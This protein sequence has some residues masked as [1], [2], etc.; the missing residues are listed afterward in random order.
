[1]SIEKFLNVLKEAEISLALDGESLVVKGAKGRLNE[2]IRTY[3]VENKEKLVEI[4]KSGRNLDGPG[5]Q[6]PPNR[7]GEAGAAIA[8][9]LLTLIELTQGDIDRIVAQV[10]GGAANIQDIYQLTPLQDG[11]LFHH[12]LADVGDPYLLTSHISFQDRNSLELFL[13]AV[14]KVVD[15]HDTLRTAFYWE[16]LSTPAQVVLRRAELQVAHVEFDAAAGPLEQQ[17]AERFDSSR[18]RIDLGRAPLLS[19]I[20]GRVRGSERC[21]VMQRFHH[22]IGDHSTLALLREEVYAILAGAEAALA[23]SEPFRNLVARV[24]SGLGQEEHERFFREMLGDVSEPSLAFGHDDVYQKGD[25]IDDAKFALPDA[26]NDRLRAQARRYGVSLA[27]LCHLAWGQVLAR[28]AGEARVVFGTVLLGRIQTNEGSGPAAGLFINTLPLRLDLGEQ[29]VETAVRKTHARLADILRHEHAPLALAQRCSGVAATAPLFNTLLNY[30]HGADEAPIEQASGNAHPLSEAVFLGNEERTNYPITLSVEDFGRSMGLT[31]QVAHPLSAARICGY[32]QRALESLADALERRPEAPVRTLD[33]LP[34]RERELLLEAWNRTEAEYSR[35]RCVHKVFEDQCRR[36]P[37]AVALEHGDL[38]VGYAELNARANRLAHDLIGS[39][40]RPGDHVATVMERGLQLVVAQLAILKAGAV[41][42]PIDRQ[43]PRARQEWILADCGAKRVLAEAP[44]AFGFDVQVIGDASADGGEA[45]VRDPELDISSEAPAYVMYTSGSTGTPKGVVVPHRAIGR[46]VVNNGYAPFDAGDAI[47]FASNPSFD[48]STMEVWGALLNGGRIVV[49]DADVFIDAARFERALARHRV[50]ALFV[51]TALFNQ[52]ARTI[53]PALAGLKYLMCGGERNDPSAFR[54]V[55]DQG[56]LQSIIHCYGPTETTTFALT[57]PI[58]RAHDG[59]ANLPIGRPIGNVRAYLLDE[60]RNPVP[61]GAVGELYIGGTGVALGYLNRPELTAER[62][63]R[64]PFAGD[65]HMY[66][67]GDLA[68]YLADG[69]LEFIGRNDHQVK[70]RGFRIELGEIETRLAELPE[71]LEAAVLAREEGGEKR[72]VAYALPADADGDS[73]SFAAALRAHLSAKLPDYMVPSAFVRMQAWPLNANGKLDRKALPAPEAAAFARGTFQPPQG[74]LEQ[75]L[76]ALWQELLGVGEVGRHDNFFELG[77]HSLLALQLVE[78]LRQLNLRVEVRR[79]FI[80]PVLCE[81][82]QSLQREGWVTVPPNA[83]A[84]DSVAITPDMLP[85][86]DLDQDEIDRIVARVPGGIANIQDIYALAPLQDGILFHHRFSDEGDP[87]VLTSLRSFPNRQLLD[88]FLGVLQRLVERHDILRTAFMWEDLSVPVQVVLREAKLPVQEFEPDPAQGP[89]AEQLAAHFDARRERMDLSRAPLLHYAFAHDRDNGRW[90]LMQ[91]FHHLI[92][93]H[94]TLDVLRDEIAALMAGKGDALAP[95][96]PFRNLVAQARLGIAQSEHEAFFRE[97]LGDVDEPTLPF[98]LADVHQAGGGVAESSLLLPDDLSRSLRQHARRLGVGVASLCHLA[99]GQVLSRIVDRDSVVFGTVLFGRIQSS[100][101][102]DRAAGLF[103]NT[104]PL[105]LDL[106]ETDVE[107]AARAAHARLADL[108]AHEH[109]SLALA[110]RCSGVAAPSPLFSSLL[111]Y[112]HNRLLDVSSEGAEDYL[113][114][115][116]VEFLGTQ[117]RTN[118]PITMSVE[119]FG[120]RLGLTALVVDALSAER[121]CGY[122]RQALESLSLALATAPRTPVRDLEVLGPQEAAAAQPAPAAAIGAS[123]PDACIHQLFEQRAH[124]DPDAIALV[125]DD[126]RLSYGELNAQ[127]N[128]LAHHLIGLGVAADERVAICAERGP[129]LVIGLLAI[130]KAGGAYVPL[131]PVYS[132]ERLETIA[133]DSAPRFV[134]ADDVGRAAL[135]ERALGERSVVDL[136]PLRAG[137]AAAWAAQCD[138]DPA[139]AGLS[140]ANLAYVIYTSGS[141][142]VPK[143]VMVE[144]TQVVRLFDATRAGF[145]FDE[146]DVW[147]L[148]HSCAFD[149]SVWELWGALRYGGRL[150]LVSHEVARSAADFYRLVCRE[151]V[152]VLN[153]TP[154]AFKAFIEAQERSDSAHALRYV[155]FGGEALEPSMLKPWYARHADGGPTLVNMYG[156]TETTVHVTYRALS[157]DD[158]ARSASPVGKPLADLRI[159]LLD[160][161]GKPVPLQATGEIYVGGAGVARGYLNREEL[162]AQR[163]LADPFDGAAGAR[164]YRSG[165]LARYGRDGELEF[166]GRNDHQVKIRGFR[167]ELG[168]IEARLTEHPWVREATV[169]AFGDGAEK[170]LA[171]YFI[172]AGDAAGDDAQEGLAAGLRAH[173]AARLPD[174]MLPSAFVEVEAWPLTPNGKLDRKALPAV[175]AQSRARRAYEAPQGE[176]ERL[177]ARLWEELLGLERVGRNDQFFELGG[178]S[179]LAVQL[180]ERLRRMH[181][182]VEVRRLFAAP[183]LRE[184]AAALEQGSGVA[185]PPNQ[186]VRGTTAITPDMLPLIDLQQEDI[187]RI[188]A[189]VPGG[190]AN[191]QDIYGL[192]PLQDGIVFHHRLTLDADPYLMRSVVTFPDRALLDRFIQAVQ[193]LVDRHDILR[194]AFFWEGL[195]APAQ[196]VL[197]QAA[198][199]VTELVLDAH[200]GP[201][202]EQLSRRYDARHHK[203]D[204]TQAPL[205]RFVI[206]R[207]PGSERWVVLQLRHHLV[208]DAVSV[209]I[210]REEIN[211]IL[212]GAAASLAEPPPFRN[213]VAQARLGLSPEQHERFFDEM[214]GDVDEPTLPYGLTDVHRD[215]GRMGQWQGTMPLALSDRLRAQAQRLGI[216]LA[217]LCH[218]AWGQVLARI[219]GN[220][221]VV[222]GTVLFGRMQAG[223]GADRAAGL[224]INTLPLRLDLGEIGAER[225]ARQ[226]H[227]RLAALMAHEHASLALAQ[228]CS[229]VG[230]PAPLFSSVVN[231]RNLVAAPGSDPAP[232]EQPLIDTQWVMGDRYTNYPMMLTLEDFGRSLGCIVHVMQPH[233]P[234]RVWDYMACALDSLATALEASPAA[235]MRSLEVLPQAERGLLLEQWNATQAPYPRDRSVHR[236]FEAQAQATPDA[237]AVVH[238]RR[239]LTFAEL[240]AEANALA[241]HLI[242]LGVRRG[243]RVAICVERGPALAIGLLAILK[244]GGAYV[245]LD[246]VYPSERLMRVLDDAAPTALL[247]D[248]SGRAALDGAAAAGCAIVDL[249]SPEDATLATAW[250]GQPTADPRPAGANSGDLAYVI[251]TSGSTGIPK[252]VQIEHRQL[253]NFLCSMASSFALAPADRWLA[254]TSISFDIAALELYLPLIS[255]SPVVLA[256]HADAIDSSRLRELIREHA[257]R[258]MQAT[259]ATWNALLAAGWEGDS[260]LTALCGGEAMPAH[261]PARLGARCKSLWNLYGPTETTIWSSILQVAPATGDAPV[262]IGRPIANT[263]MYLLDEA[264]QPVPLGA[265]GELYIGG[266]GVARGYHNR[267]ELNAERFLHDPFAGGEARM[268]RTGDQARYLTDGNIEFLGRNDHQVKIRG[269]R[270]EL[271]EIE[272]RLAGHASVREAVVTVREDHGDKRLVA[273]VAGA[274]EHDEWIAELRAHLSAGLPDY[275]VPAAIVRLD[276]LPLTPNGKV[277][278]KALPA[279]DESSYAQREFEAPE[280][281]IER[282]L[283]GLWQSLLQVDKV[284]RHHDFF[285]LGGHSLLVVRLLARVRQS[286]GVEL[287]VAAFFAHST[288]ARLAQAVADAG[289]RAAEGADAPIV[290]VSREQPMPLSFAQQRLWFLAQLDGVS[291]T[292]HMP[293]AL[294]IRG[295]LDRAALRRTLDALMARHEALRSVFATV[296]GQPQLR[297]LPAATPLPL[298]EYDFSERDDAAA[299]LASLGEAETKLPFDLANG[300]LIRARLIRMPHDEHVL[301][302]CQHHIVSDGWS[303]G[304][305]TREL[306]QLYAAFSEGRENP[307]APLPIQYPDYAAWQ[308]QWLGGERLQRQAEFWRETLSEVPALLELPTDRPRPAK[309]DFAAALVPVAFDAELTASLRR[310]SQAHGTTLFMTLMAAW[311]TVLSRLSGQEQVVVGVPTANRGRPETEGLLGLFVNT[312][313]LPVRLDGEPSVGELLARVRAT[314]LAAQDHQDLPFEQVVEIVRPQRSLNHSPL[315]Q[316]LFNWQNNDVRLPELGSLH[317]EQAATRFD[318]VKFDLELSLGEADGQIQGYLKYVTSLFDAETVQRQIGYL[319]ALLKAMVADAGQPVAGIDLLSPAER[320]LQLETWNDTD[321]PFPQDLCIHQLFERQAAATPEAVAV[322]CGDRALGYRDLNEQANKLAHGL[323]GRGVRADARVAICVERSLEMVVGL[324]AIMKAG[325]AYVPLDLSYPRDRLAQMLDDAAPAMVLTDAAGREALGAIVAADAIVLDLHQ[326]Q[327]WASMP[328]G[329]PVAVGLTSRNLAYIIYTSGSTGRPKGV[330]TEHRAVVNRL[331]WIQQGYAPLDRDEVVLQKTSFAFDVSVWELFWPLLNG[332]RLALAPPGAHKDPAALIGLVARHGVTTVHFVPSM[333]SV[334]LA[335]PGV[336]GCVSLRKLFCSGEAL[337]AANVYGWQRK[338]PGAQLYNLYGPTE[339]AIEASAWTCPREFDGRVLIG[340]PIANVRMYV[341]DAAGRPAPLGAIG[342]LHIGGTAVA[343]GYLNRPELTAERFLDDPFDAGPDARMYKSGDL[344]RYLADGRIECLGRNDDQVKVRGFRIELGEIRSRLGGHAKVREAHVLARDYGEEKRLIGYVVPMQADAAGADL[345]AELRTHLATVLPDY[346]V[347]SAIVCLDRLPVTQNGK[348]DHKALPEPEEGAAERAGYQAPVGE[349]ELALAALWQELLQVERV[350]RQDEFFELG[351]HSLLAVRMLAHIRQRLGVELP[352][353]MLFGSS[354]L[355]GLAAALADAGARVGLEGLP[356][357]AALA[358]DRPLPL[359]FAQQRL[360]ILSQWEG[361]S[362]TY[363][364]PLA[365]RIRGELDKVALRRSLDA[366]VARHE[367]LR[368]VFDAVGGLPQV[369]VLGPDLGFRMLEHDLR[370]EPDASAQLARIGEEEARSPFDLAQ[371]P[372]IRGRL[373]QTG[374]QEFVLLLTQHHIVSDGWSVGVLSRELN[375]LYRAFRAGRPNPLAPLEIQYPDYAAWQNQWLSGERLARQTEFWRRALADAPVLLELPTDRPRPEQQEF[376]AGRVAIEL[377]ADATAALKRLSQRHGVTLFMTLMAAWA[378]VLSRLSGQDEVVIGTPT[379]NRGRPETEG[380]IGFFVNTLALPVSVAG[381]PSVRELLERVRSI[382]LA[383]Q[384]HQDLPFEQVVEIVQP[385]RRLD[386]TPIFQAMFSWQ[387]HEQNRLELPGLQVSP[388]G[389]AGVEPVKFDLELNLNEIGDVVRGDLSYAKSLFDAQTI[390]R[391]VGYLHSALRAMAADSE[392]AVDA[393]ELLSSAER[394]LLLRTWNA[395]DADYPRDRCIHQLIEARAHRAPDAIALVHRDFSLSYGALNAQANRLA[396][397][398]IGLGVRPDDTVAICVDRGPALIVGQL[399][400]LKAG[401][402]YVPLDPVYPSE[403]LG[404]VL[405]D[406]MP[407]IVLADAAGRAALDAAALTGRTVVALDPPGPAAQAP[408]AALPDTDPQVPALAPT[409]LAYVIYTSGSTGLPKGV[410]IEHAGL[411]NQVTVLQRSY[412]LEPGDR[413]LQFAGPSFDMSVEEIFGALASGATLVLGDRE[414][415]ADPQR[416]FELCESYGLTVANL[417]TRFWQQLAQDPQ[418]PMAPSLRQIAI[419][420]EAVSAAALAAWWSRPG[421]RPALWNAYGPTEATVNACLLRCEASSNPRSIGA[422][423]A[424]GRIYLL[425]AHAHP[426]PRGSVGEIHIGGVGVARGYLNRPDLTAERFLVDPFRDEPGARMYKSG[427]LA[428]Y[429]P[430]G[431]LEFLGRND[432]QVKIRGFRIELGEIEARL[433]EHPLVREAMVLVREEH[434]D[435]RLVAYVTPS[436][437]ESDAIEWVVALRTHLMARLPDYMVPSAFVRIEEWPLTPNGKLD[438]KAL[439]KPDADAYAQGAYEAP[440]GGV[441]PVLARIWQALLRTDRIGRHDNFFELGGHSLLAVQMLEQ[442]RQHG[443]GTDIR[444]IFAAPTIAKLAAALDTY[445]DIDV[446]ANAIA[447]DARTISP[448]MLPLIEL[449]QRDIDRIVAQVPGGVANVQDIYALSPLQEGLLFHHL[450]ASAGDPYL[451]VSVLSFADRGL[452]DRFVGAVQAVVDRHDILRTAFFWEGLST[453]AQVVLRKVRMQ[454]T[455]LELD[456]DEGPIADQLV[457][458]FDTYH[459]RIDISQAPLLRFFASWDEQNGRWLLLYL[460]HH[461]VD[462]HAS[463]STLREE[464]YA[465]LSGRGDRLGAS[466]PFRN[467]VAR[468]RLGVP[469]DEHERYFRK[470]LAGVTEPT[471]PFGLAEVHEDDRR[472]GRAARMLPAPLRDRL[473]AQARRLGVGLASLCHLAWGHVLARSVSHPTVVFGTVLFGRMQAEERM[474]QSVGLFINTLPFRVD[475]GRGDAAAD[476]RRVHDQLAELLLHEHASLAAAQRCSDVPANSPLFSALLNYRHSDAPAAADEQAAG[477]S[478]ELDILHIRD[479]VRNNYPITMC[480]DDFGLDIGLTGLVV[481]S[482]GAER[483]CGY[484]ERAL[485]SLADE[486][487]SAAHGALYRLEILAPRERSQLLTEW[488]ATEAWYPQDRSVHGLFEEQAQ[489]TPQAPAVVHGARTLSYA[490]VNEQANRLAHRLIELG[491]GAQTRVAIC[492]DRSPAMVIAM[493]AV[494]KSGAAYVPLD[495]AYPSERLA[496][497]LADAAPGLVLSDAAGRAALGEAA[498]DGRTALDLE[499]LCGEGDAATAWSDRPASDPQVAGATSSDLAYVIYTSG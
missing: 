232:A 357:I 213:L 423:I 124:E 147:C 168:E 385:P 25:G 346:M 211:A 241:H 186:I 481:E 474:G 398:L 188:L 284:G 406:A 227:D 333:L 22:L 368:T 412:G 35:E 176:I 115:G 424:N 92:G 85:L 427:D 434:A 12:R 479:E 277:D 309:Q 266:D 255:G 206:A 446:P 456:G 81:L 468:A 95:P 7:I 394:E 440:Q 69:N 98:G 361:V 365:M 268:Y 26:L 493:L 470:M 435:R 486:L 263:R 103:I 282:V 466:Q 231:Y 185:V 420:G 78:R 77:G 337:P 90:L 30:R 192:A 238:R 54:S 315:F 2:E 71:V 154:S 405:V 469:R 250:A 313:A 93:D 379:A 275:M 257:I 296:D 245:P 252:G 58:T 448:E 458:R 146:R 378:A 204:L 390:E 53:A 73:Q 295:D 307:L 300:P 356:P 175:D 100:D 196:V 339:T 41:Y 127:A 464:V 328:A 445:R 409:N 261:F 367:T 314:V 174:Y 224:F 135:G 488:N 172:A 454:V 437:P 8:P 40:I 203:V 373:V 236:L 119:D 430:N 220:E 401:G 216:G 202:G 94:S 355:A 487:E 422:P 134:L 354:T 421:H 272:A 329:D 91:R 165:D 281:E 321:A 279:P 87:Y 292:Y 447:A 285:E 156:I 327:E 181:L 391:Q 9:E 178:H 221:R 291:A 383:A 153:Q 65:G 287:P 497:V 11:I 460:T 286:L 5:M 190:I 208:E 433:S 411:C 258:I 436:E 161:H 349:I 159:H 289:G 388:E 20:V 47:A 494:L 130:L 142:G 459:Y 302:L 173:L 76:A 158:C 101:G 4:L 305:L 43:L 182:H 413:V 222:F 152:T 13:Q 121:I 342:E 407:S 23:P 480:V 387:K 110:Q 271:G 348:L 197:R 450:Q 496:Q 294:R 137:T 194:T 408:W 80:A 256:D 492:A 191:V 484:M 283:A 214:L 319:S 472:I 209:Q 50:T 163:F 267:P 362:A 402:A 298:V 366:L 193:V 397:H 237:V 269:F 17:L 198:L 489:R 344:V 253:T 371:G 299:Q 249:P 455:E 133:A 207:E 179:L 120:E 471:L 491:A 311:A 438:H 75:T 157:A 293:A 29:S 162:T 312:L 308:R 444:T 126:G 345:A 16:G 44:E 380:M 235:P 129:A 360:W 377:D 304:V 36:T 482:L 109:A 171:A 97:M 155:I 18:N 201:A 381:S 105:R 476:V 19:F 56:G 32:M 61:V 350:G 223:D 27:S 183:V 125:H 199:S 48:A 218:L 88:S 352:L 410:M 37:D 498:L 1:M 432:H 148:F 403:R 449:E 467:L 415:I 228:R 170:Q 248:R 66:R 495:P 24:R 338:L 310:L 322:V 384:D 117:E 372:L 230:A 62:F 475:L 113:L 442:L 6:V 149:F 64:D 107:T 404:H 15:R 463:L 297:L 118:Y 382:A 323:I 336:E 104:L 418:V 239:S 389:Q 187:D 242:G 195:S 225:A 320:T 375:E 452:M 426:V 244:A 332:A 364:I 112:R 42:V 240:N 70:I 457:R 46:L 334:F 49:I 264:A 306:T 499:P 177:L 331:A 28:S 317:V 260:E 439:P 347:P 483:M 251:Y 326:P 83:I 400:I 189:Q 136:Q 396:H 419:G 276:S 96:P 465:I 102:A 14:Q 462:D 335:T 246:P 145:D 278:R 205:I 478:P 34:Q 473:R 416:W 79:L 330:M 226:A 116:E 340:R 428:R 262:S 21:V 217:S 369:R 184:L 33:I 247:A 219:V 374:E 99:W 280:G 392:Q 477:V 303:I 395:T 122:M 210:Y 353:A 233:S 84:A 485:E 51:T 108:L 431:H 318:F 265:I 128:R 453:P 57:C 60:H 429:L 89:L 106:D 370:G 144:H 160:R 72:L 341:L 132:S 414:W 31:A 151:G 86:V 45:D 150:V 68:R 490:Q 67:T 59:V 363:H 386:H 82:A 140:P 131:D 55:L 274:G 52:Y 139:V 316:V 443:L 376:A 3:L 325:G 39:G 234:E 10:P 441:E 254:V 270:I 212:Q 273:Y 399:A 229:G 63:L 74:E 123:A 288:L 167:I 169:L 461:L 143:G 301:F 38:V 417:P 425:D 259:P 200:D 138:R 215:G 290:P 343:R 180:I 324:M 358:R 111:N 359:S 243:D 114:L 451:H 393:I 351:G 166:L 141:T 164:M